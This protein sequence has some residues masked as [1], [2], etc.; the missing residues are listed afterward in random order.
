[1]SFTFINPASLGA[2]HG[3]SNGVLTEGGRLLFVAGQIAWDQQ[4]QIVSADIVEQFDRA[5]A[6]VLAV[7]TEAGGKPAQIARLV[8]YVTDK[9]E[10][11]ERMKEIGER[12]RAR[13]GRHF[14]AMVLVEVKS[15][16]E[17]DARIEIE[18]IAVLS[19]FQ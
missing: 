8:I 9:N 5:L 4:Q 14:P 15:L 7:V 1:M 10:Y 3:Y 12:Y 18:G 6:N 17:D 11:R 13:M 2:P 19:D 16:L